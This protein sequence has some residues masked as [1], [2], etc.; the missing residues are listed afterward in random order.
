[1]KVGTM[2][3]DLS[4]ANLEFLKCIGVNHVIGTDHRICG[5]DRLGHWDAGELTDLRKHVEAHGLK[6]VM[7][8][9][10]QA[11]SIDKEDLP[12]I[13]LATSGRDA[14][15]ERFLKCVRAAA[16]AGIP[17]IKINFSVGGVLRTKP[18]VGRGGALHTALNI[19]EFKTPFTKAG[20]ITAGEMWER[21][22]YFVQKVIPVAEE[23]G[24]RIA[25]HPHDPAMPLGMGMDD[26]VLG[27]IDGLKKYCDLSPSPYHGL[28]YCQGC[29]E[30][31]GASQEELLEAI[32]YF[33]TRKRLF[34]VHFRTIRGR[35]L[36]F[37]EAFIDE[38]QMDMLAAMRAYQEVGYEHVIVPDH[39]P[40]IPGD[41]D[42]RDSRA[43]A[44]G[45]MKALIRATG[46]ET[47]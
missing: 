38:G 15:I 4:A 25:C 43:Y 27:T 18:A 42:R 40:Q 33:G 37:R 44:V 41:V 19:D 24:V 22:T 29:M 21:I 11:Q 14:D 45:Y 6:L 13:V 31:S 46:G 39:Y 26:R 20:R 2:E 10:M 47:D 8:G 30:E 1:M 35:A 9:I 17:A 23:V 16:K 3:S 34:L 7:L 5:W 12:N 36:H 32:R 28:N